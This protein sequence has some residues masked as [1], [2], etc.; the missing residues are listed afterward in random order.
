MKT[1]DVSVCL[2]LGARRSIGGAGRKE[3]DCVTCPQERVLARA[4]PCTVR[5][6]CV[7]P[8]SE[9]WVGGHR[10][11]VPPVTLKADPQTSPHLLVPETF[12]ERD[13]VRLGKKTPQAVG[14]QFQRHIAT[15]PA[16]EW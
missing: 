16:P 7:S 3:L 13:R 1:H 14:G 5:P 4:R 15:F 6:C 8:S 11:V 2:V 10:R 9:I 12:L